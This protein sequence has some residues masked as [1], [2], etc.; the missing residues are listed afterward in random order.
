LSRWGNASGDDWWYTNSWREA[1]AAVSSS[2]LS[3]ISIE[4][5]NAKVGPLTEERPHQLLWL[6]QEQFTDLQMSCSISSAEP[7]ARVSR[8]D[9]W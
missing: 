6:T 5:V 4:K 2:E 7:F 1:D 8:S 3:R 9:S